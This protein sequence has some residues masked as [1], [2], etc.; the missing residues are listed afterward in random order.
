M[1]S[2]YYTTL[3]EK[4]NV[5]DHLPPP[6]CSRSVQA[7]PQPGG[8]AVARRDSQDCTLRHSLACMTCDAQVLI[9][10]QSTNLTAGP[11]FLA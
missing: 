11:A 7:E 4:P 2:A 10:L 3:N 5:T 1:L 6:H 9:N 8:D